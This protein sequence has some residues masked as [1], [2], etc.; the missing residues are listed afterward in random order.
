MTRRGPGAELVEFDGV[1]HLPALM[2]RDQ[3][4]PVVSFLGAP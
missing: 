4:E 3:I 1:G 2:T